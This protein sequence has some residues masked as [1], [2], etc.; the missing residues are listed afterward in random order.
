MSH[1]CLSPTRRMRLWLP[2]GYT[3]TFC[4]NEENTVF[5]VY[6]NDLGQVMSFNYVSNPNDTTWFID[7]NNTITEQV[8]I[9]DNEGT[10]FLATDSDE[11]TNVIV[12]STKDQAA[13]LISGFVDEAEL[14]RMKYFGGMSIREI[15]DSLELPYETV[16][17]RHQRTLHK[18]RRQQDC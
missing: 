16:K 4:D 12:W 15:A 7:Q 17:K 3:E 8:S 2:E 18:L 6:S 13:F 1:R 5:V 10:L 9:N 11:N 14:I